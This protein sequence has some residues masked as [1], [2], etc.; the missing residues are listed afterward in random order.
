MQLLKNTTLPQQSKY[1]RKSFF[2]AGCFLKTLVL[3]RMTLTILTV[4]FLVIY[5]LLIFF[6]FFHWNKLPAYQ[7]PAGSSVFVSV[8]IAARNEEATLPL[9]LNDLRQQNYPQYLFE[10][11]VVDDYSADGTATVLQKFANSDFKMILPGVPPEASSKKM[12]IAAG[13]KKAAGELLI[14]TDADCRVQSEWI[15]TIASFYELNN[16]AFIAAPVKF[17]HDGSLLEIFQVLDF[18]SLQ[19]LTAASVSANFHSMCNGANLAYTKQAF[20]SVNGFAGI[21]KVATG[22]D[23]LLMHKIWKKQPNKVFYLKS[24]EA[25]VTTAPM[26]SWKDFLMQRKRWASKT[27][28]YNDYRIVAVLAFVLAFNILFFVLL[29]AAFF[30]K[31]YWVHFFFALLGKTII[32]WPLVS[33]VAHFYGEQKLMRHF[34]FIQPL[35]IFYTVFVGIISQFGK[36]EWKGR[37]TR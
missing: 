24:K 26:K 6:Y 15:K 36:Y 33:S 34:F 28:V 5:A 4:G 21:D 35:H 16:A 12:A 3:E 23:M 14:I 10:V 25:I 37:R 2:K 20:E 31:V 8:I 17:T 27:L 11:I 30:N 19:G 22:D 13:V 9:L 32:E 1:F 18:I 7:S 29:V